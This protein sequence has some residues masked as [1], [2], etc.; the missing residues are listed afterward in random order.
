MTPFQKLREFHSAFGA[1]VGENPSLPDA[2][3]R[4]LR[5]RILKEEWE[6]YLKAEEENDL[7]EIADALAD[8]IYIA[9]G[10]GVAYGLP[11]DAIF[12]EVHRS[13]MAKLGPDGKPIRRD[14]GK[15]LKPEGWTPP[16]VAGVIK[17]STGS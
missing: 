16:D 13:N 4:A 8:M 15:I 2:E 1:L 5:I 6:E 11:M 10:T 17:G 3:T 9:Y 14:D 7:V 12:D